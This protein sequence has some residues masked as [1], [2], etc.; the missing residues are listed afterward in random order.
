[1]DGSGNYGSSN[2][3]RLGC[4][5]RCK[6]VKGATGCEVIWNQ[7]NKGCY[8]HTAEVARGNGVGNHYCWVMAKC[9]TPKP[10]PAAIVADTLA[11]KGFKTTTFHFKSIWY[12]KNGADNID[13]LK[14][15]MT[16]LATDEGAL[17]A[18]QE[19]AKQ[20][21]EEAQALLAQAELAAAAPDT[22]FSSYKP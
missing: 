13:E 11:S 16:A 12:K 5:E 8:V 2:D 9:Y 21:E 1:M 14:A 6:T 18:N 22:A 3:A 7:W 17:L 4:L 20:A 19:K 10:K 15:R